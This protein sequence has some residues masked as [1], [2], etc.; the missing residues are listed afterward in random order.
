MGKGEETGE[1][2]VDHFEGPHS[3]KSKKVRVVFV[4]RVGRPKRKRPMRCTSV[5]SRRSIWARFA[6][7]YLT[8]F[9]RPGHL[10]YICAGGMSRCPVGVRLLAVWTQ[11]LLD[12]PARP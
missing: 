12:P 4:L 6:L 7:F 5:G 1:C 9:K 2:V 11:E 8:C 3:I 10:M